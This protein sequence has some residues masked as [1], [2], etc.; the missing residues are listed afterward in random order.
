MPRFSANLSMLFTEVPFLERFAAARK[1]GFSAVEFQ[2]P[3]DFAPSDIA[4]RVEDNGLEVVLFNVPAGDFAAGERGV[5]CLPD[6]K[7]DFR[8]GLDQMLDY[9][10][11]LRC[12]RINCLAGI[13]PRDLAPEVARVT[14]IENMQLARDTVPD[15]I[16]L[17][18]EPLN[19]KDNPGYFLTTSAAGM[20]IIS[21]CNRPGLALQYDVY[22]MQRMEGDILT[23]LGQLLPMIG[24]IQIAD[25]P[26]RG[27]PG[28]GELNFP[29]IF[30]WLDTSD[31]GGWVGC[32]YKPVAGTAEGLAWLDPLRC[33]P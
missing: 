30:R 28:T 19:N 4:V 5:T 25:V 17:L 29:K 31:Y 14:M 12:P 8:R 24:H 26:G 18:L 32:E 13:R 6:R 1:A 15:A 16:T 3:Y 22:H 2:F 11:R 10:G 33:T 23:T 7:H 21:A 27:E 20:D 9:A